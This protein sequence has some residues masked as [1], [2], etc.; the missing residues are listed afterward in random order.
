MGENF[1]NK[2]YGIGKS[3]LY[4][5][6]QVSSLPL[7]DGGTLFLNSLINL[8]NFFT[9]HMGIFPESGQQ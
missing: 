8:G 3:E 1:H 5:Y 4:P 7:R 9:C 2:D 6:T